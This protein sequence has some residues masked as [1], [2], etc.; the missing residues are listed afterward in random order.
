M[1]YTSHFLGTFPNAPDSCV[2]Y[3]CNIAIYKKFIFGHSN[4]QNIFLVYLVLL[5][6]FW[7]T[8]PKTLEISRNKGFIGVFCYVNG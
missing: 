6:G 7:L 2:I 3:V 5:Q 4:D 1:L 8:A